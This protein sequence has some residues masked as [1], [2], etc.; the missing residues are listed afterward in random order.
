MAWVEQV[1]VI[2]CDDGVEFIRINV[3]YDKAEWLENKHKVN[4][5]DKVELKQVRG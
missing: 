5:L 2:S 3:I 4:T 1:T